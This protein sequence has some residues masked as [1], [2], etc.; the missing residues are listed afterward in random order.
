[1]NQRFSDY[2]TP[3]QMKSVNYYTYFPVLETTVN[4]TETCRLLPSDDAIAYDFE[5]EPDTKKILSGEVSWYSE[6]LYKKIDRNNLLPEQKIKAEFKAAPKDKCIIVNLLDHCFGHSFVKFLNIIDFY[7]QYSV[8]HDLVL[9]SFGYVKDY[10]PAGKFSII[11]LDLSFGEVQKLYSLKNVISLVRQQYKEVDFAVLE[12]FKKFEDKEK[13]PSFFNF[14]GEG[15]NPY[16]GKK[17]VVFN[18]RKGFDRSWNALGQAKRVT[19]LFVELKKYLSAEVVFCVIGDKD[20]YHF[21]EWVLDKRIDKFPNPILYEYNYILKNTVFAIG[22]MGSHMITASVL[23]DMTVHLTPERYLRVASTDIVNYKTT[24]TQSYFTHLYLQGNATTSDL[25]PKDVAYKI[26]LTFVGRLLVEHKDAG[27]EILKKKGKVPLQMEY[28]EQAHPYF[29]YAR[30]LDW[31]KQ[32]D[33]K[34]TQHIRLKMLMA[35]LLFRA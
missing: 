9:L 24:T 10:L 35:K 7:E 14:F 13:L 22:L 1:M 20:R 33:G 23:S 17:F 21:P 30:F 27:H 18:Y 11:H 2:L 8:T 32:R 4:G 15:P 6:P 12:A 5:F 19:Q 16:P 34:F 25:K 28:I 26:L 3:E 29:N 31:K